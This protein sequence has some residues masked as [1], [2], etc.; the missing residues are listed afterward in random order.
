MILVDEPRVYRTSLRQKRWCHMVSDTSE[1]EL[2]AFARLLGMKRE[3]YQG[4]RGRT[5]HYDLTPTRRALA[6]KHGAV[7]VSTK[8]LVKRHWERR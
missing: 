1:E 8:V 6:I 5:P 2:H 7:E 3:W 4:R